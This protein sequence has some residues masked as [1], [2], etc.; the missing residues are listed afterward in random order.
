VAEGSLEQSDEPM[1]KS[2]TR[3]RCGTPEWD[4]SLSGALATVNLERATHTVGQIVV[5]HNESPD[6]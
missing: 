1:N 4:E 2:A 3:R 5:I 6:A